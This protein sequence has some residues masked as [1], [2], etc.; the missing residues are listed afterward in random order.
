MPDKNHKIFKT[1]ISILLSMQLKVRKNELFDCLAVGDSVEDV[2]H[3][4]GSLGENVG[5]VLLGE[6]AVA[7][8]SSD[9][10]SEGG[11]DLVVEV[12]EVLLVEDE[13]FIGVSFIFGAWEGGVDLFNISEDLV[14]PLGSSFN[15]LVGG[16]GVV[17][18][19]IEEG[20]GVASDLVKSLD[21]AKQKISKSI[22][23]N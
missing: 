21:G 2:L 13:G 8:V 11:S 7:A 18:G 10:G 1:N 15:V 23:K 14:N 5:E 19:K 16:G 17:V 3:S 4:V 9:E 20:I 12:A 6:G 22:A